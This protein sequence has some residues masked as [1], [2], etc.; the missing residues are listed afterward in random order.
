MNPPNVIMDDKGFGDW[1][2][3][4][5]STAV[6]TVTGVE[7]G[8]RIPGS[9]YCPACHIAPDNVNIYDLGGGGRSDPADKPSCSQGVKTGLYQNDA[10]VTCHVTTEMEGLGIPQWSPAGATTTGMQ[11]YNIANAQSHNHSS[12]ATGVPC[13]L[14][15]S[16]PHAMT[17]PNMAVDISSTGDINNQCEYCHNRSDGWINISSEVIHT[18]PGDCANCHISNNKLD[19]HLVPVGVFGGKWCLDCHNL[20]GT[21]P[22]NM[23]VDPAIADASNFEYIHAHLND[24]SDT[25]NSSRICWGCHTND[26]YVING[27]VNSTGIP[28]SVHPTGYETPRN[29]TDCHH[30]TSTYNFGAPQNVRHTWYSLD[31]NTPFVTSCADCHAQDEML[32]TWT[33]E[34][35][36]PSSENQAV[37]HYGKNRTSFFT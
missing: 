22:I 2:W 27:R 29:C 23:K 11:N 7:W 19:S 14:C 32:N 35:Y 24:N 5:S 31:M 1:M 20:T 16:T 34:V 12:N 26:S 6:G 4:S 33:E 36:P 18:S 3:N 37:S 13:A 8:S 28:D 10:T 9:R 25:T 17:M 21:S 30:N 15:H